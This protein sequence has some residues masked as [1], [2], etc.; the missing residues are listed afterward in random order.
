M[1]GPEGPG[2][3][4]SIS[5]GPGGPGRARGRIY[6][7]PGAD[8]SDSGRIHPPPGSP[9]ALPGPQ[10]RIDP[11]PCLLNWGRTA[12]RC[13]AVTPP[14]PLPCRCS[15]RG[16]LHPPVRLNRR[17]GS[18]R[19]PN[20]P[21]WDFPDLHNTGGFSCCFLGRSAPPKAATKPTGVANPES[22]RS[23]GRATRRSHTGGSPS[24]SDTF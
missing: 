20:P 1:S 17:C 23:V 3:D 6:R 24:L 4:I 2:S 14:R 16:Q 10:G 12:W 13:S 21:I 7:N 9:G 8:I 18:N 19:S 22:P 5:G 15:V 11:P